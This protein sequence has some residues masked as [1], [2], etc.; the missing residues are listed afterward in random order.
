ML[1]LLV[2]VQV[3]QQ[4]T[5][6]KTIHRAGGTVIGGVAAVAL[7]TWANEPVIV[8]VGFLLFVGCA[9]ASMGGPY[10]LYAAFL[11]P[12]VVL[13]TGSF[14]DVASRDIQRVGYTLAGSILAL[15]AIWLA[16][17]FRDKDPSPP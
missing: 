6:I 17:L 14:S 10:W 5:V 11:T 15:A 7:V 16:S 1:T 12:V 3:G 8:V 9:A 4:D 2:V 13:T